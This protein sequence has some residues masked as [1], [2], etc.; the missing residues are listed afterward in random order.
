MAEQK[1]RDFLLKIRTATG[2]DVFTTVAGMRTTAMQINE[3][4]VDITNKDSAG[5]R[6]LLDGRIVQSMQVSAEGVFKDEATYRLLQTTM[7]AGTHEEYQIVIP[8]TIG[9]AAGTFEGT[10][11]ITN[12]ETN[13]DYNNEMTFSVTLES[14]GQIAFTDLAS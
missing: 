3:E 2:P 6:E 4:S 11:R 1:G 9:G 7:L 8:G 5:Y 12:L 13:G 14:D 10:F